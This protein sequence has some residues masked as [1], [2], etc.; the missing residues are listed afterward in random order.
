M[1]KKLSRG[2]LF[3]VVE[4]SELRARTQALVITA[5]GYVE[6]KSGTSVHVEAD[7]TPGKNYDIALS[8]KG[9]L[10]LVNAGSDAP[11]S[12]VV[13]GAFYSPGSCA[14]AFD[15]GDST[16]QWNPFSLWDSAWRPLCRDPRGMTLV[17]GRF[18]SSIWLFA[19]GNGRIISGL[20]LFKAVSL[21]AREG[22]RL[23]TLDE[24]HRLAVGVR[25]RSAPDGYQENVQL[26]SP[27][28]SRWGVMQATGTRWVWLNPA[29]DPTDVLSA[30]KMRA[31]LA[32][33]SWGG[34]ANCGSR[35]VVW[36]D[37]PW[38]SNSVFGARACCDHLEL[39]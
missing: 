9:D 16:P 34:G 2:P 36:Y 26:D 28:T 19:D 24:Y 27:R 3:H 23:P 20:N 25:E 39:V 37:S 13:G 38:D 31:P 30:E 8:K 10:S 35:C 32:G 11:A 5:D 15:G 33:G 6:I 21:L 18:W 17:E 14:P 1:I 4:K 29:S 22:K 12:Q 7:L